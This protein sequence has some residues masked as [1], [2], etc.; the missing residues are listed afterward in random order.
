[1]LR[2]LPFLGA[3]GPSIDEWLRRDFSTGDLMH[4]GKQILEL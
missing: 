2:Y 4:P 1:V 3:R